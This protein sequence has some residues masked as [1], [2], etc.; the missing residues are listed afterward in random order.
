MNDWNV[1][2]KF[3]NGISQQFS[4]IPIMLWQIPG[5]HLQVIGDMDTR[6]DHAS[7]AS[8]YFL[9]DTNL[10][11]KLSNVKNYIA[12]GQ[13]NPINYDVHSASVIEYLQ[14]PNT[15]SDCWHHNR[16][17]SPMMKNVFAILWGGGSTTGII[18]VTSDLD[19]NGW[20]YKKFHNK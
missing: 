3:V 20:L 10:D 11:S 18:G 1:Y 14:C 6:D 19:D 13:I 17:A 5:G 16:L 12:Q 8:S 15:D 7:S 9:G 2:M 4:N